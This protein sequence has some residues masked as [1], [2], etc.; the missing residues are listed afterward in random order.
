MKKLS[1]LEHYCNNLK[2][3]LIKLDSNYGYYSYA[4]LEYFSSLSKGEL[5]RIC[6]NMAVKFSTKYKLKKAKSKN[7]NINNSLTANFN[8]LKT[9]I[10]GE[11][12]FNCNAKD[13]KTYNTFSVKNDI[14][15]NHDHQRSS[16]QYVVNNLF[17]ENLVSQNNK[18]ELENKTTKSYNFFDR[19]DDVR[20]LL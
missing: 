13:I 12:G 3:H 7:S 8:D 11:D 9:S 5:F 10:I 6:E 18:I 17:K 1:G 15:Q 20:K 2:T 19:L 14:N 4:L 16:I